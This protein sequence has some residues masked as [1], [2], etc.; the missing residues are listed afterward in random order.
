[1]R[2]PTC[3]AEQPWSEACRRCRSDLRLL[4]ETAEEYAA[5]RAACL[6]AL[7]A[8]H[9]RTALEHVQACMRLRPDHPTRQLLAVCALLN[10]DW[11][12]A[13]AAARSTE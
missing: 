4:R 1:M 2:C 6:G 3:R 9:Y 5:L 8:G 10:E 11:P 12:A 7:N 13:L